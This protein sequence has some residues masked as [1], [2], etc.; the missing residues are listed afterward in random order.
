MPFASGTFTFTSNSFAPTPVAATTISES[1]AT[2]TWSELAT[3]LSTCLLKDGSQTV[4]A[5]IP[6]SSNK[7]TGLSAGSAAGNSL[8]YEQLFTTS[9]VTILGAMDW[10]KGAD[11]ASAATVN[12]TTATG[13]AVHITGAVTI[14]AVTLGSGM[15]R[16][17]IFDGA[18][19]LTHH[20]TNN[21]LPG[22]SDITTAANDRALYWADGTTV[23]CMAYIKA[24]GAPVKMS[25]IT[26]SLSGDV[27]LTDTSLYFTGP[28]IS[29]GTVGT[30]LASGTVSV[31]DTT[32][33]ATILAKL[34]DGTTVIAS[35]VAYVGGANQYV[36]I[37]L[38]GYLSAPAGNL[39]ISVKDAT[40]TT[41]IMTFNDSG[42]SKDATLSA[43]RIA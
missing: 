30:W 26:N 2:S 11:I 12:L 23:Y 5:D 22:G 40:N 42:N 41:G 14:T 33:G 19:T 43:I 39:R 38:S 29:Q 27:N 1:A 6:M 20:A 15:F 17:V 7:L 32:A 35:G 34:W 31:K 37:S 3:A 10:K 9:A 4:T 8:R 18:L 13:N 21:N 28:T 24:S 16:M 25:Q 36:A